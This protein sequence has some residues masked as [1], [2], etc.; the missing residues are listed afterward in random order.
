MKRDPKQ[1]YIEDHMKTIVVKKCF[2]LIFYKKCAKCGMEYKKEPMYSCSKQDSLL[3]HTNYTMGCSH[4][5]NN[6][7]EFKK[8]AEDNGYLYTEKSLS[9]TWDEFSFLH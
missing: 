6:K 7:E 2:P 8:W 9:E 3:T 1:K 5:F 4:C